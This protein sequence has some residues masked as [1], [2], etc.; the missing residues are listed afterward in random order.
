MTWYHLFSTSKFF[1]I[2]KNYVEVFFK[3]TDANL[4]RR[5]N[6]GLLRYLC[7]CSYYFCSTGGVLGQDGVVRR[8]IAPGKAHPEED[9]CACPHH[10]SQQLTQET[11]PR[12]QCA[13]AHEEDGADQ[14]LL[15]HLAHR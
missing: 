15:R 10:R 11:P 9:R 13:V 3:E 5:S 8:Q 12:R 4:K 2:L 1:D 7:D 14:T 6:F